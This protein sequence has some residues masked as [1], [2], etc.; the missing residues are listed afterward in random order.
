MSYDLEIVDRIVA[1][2]G[3]EKRAVIPILQA[4]QKEFKFLPQEALDRTQSR[5]LEITDSRHRQC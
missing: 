1:D 5:F 3:R 2:K 4:V